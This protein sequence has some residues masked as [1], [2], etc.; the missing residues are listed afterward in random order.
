MIHHLNSALATP[1]PVDVLVVGAGGTGSQ[2]VTALAQMH[3]ALTSLDHP[4]LQVTVLDDD[5]VSLSNIGRQ[6]FFKADLGQ[7][8]AEVL[9]NRCNL[10][11][12]TS[13]RAVRGK[14]SASDRVAHA[15]VIGCVDTRESRYAIMRAMEEGI[16]GRSYWL[17]FGNRRYDGQV[18]LGEVSRARRKTNEPDKLPHVGELFPEAIDPSAV[19]PD[20]GP[21]CSL[22]E[23][24]RKQSLFI[25]RTLVAH[26]MGMLWELLHTGQIDYHGVWVN[27][28]TGRSSSLAVDPAAWERFG[29]GRQKAQIRKSKMRKE[30]EAAT[31]PA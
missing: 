15:L 23:A 7:S 24:L 29:Y 17:D 4:G 20:E 28:K 14:L 9:V 2:V 1:R 21:S 11:L 26:G 22:A 18:I 5:T 12:G 13:W 25:N 3:H 27:L 16:R 19:D 30:R 31:Q 10:T 6:W 8:K